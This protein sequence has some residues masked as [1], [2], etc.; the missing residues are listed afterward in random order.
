[1][2]TKMI[3]LVFWLFFLREF[4]L[5]FVMVDLHVD[6]DVEYVANV[7]KFTPTCNLSMSPC[8]VYCT[9]FQPGVTLS[10][11]LV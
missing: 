2:I 1:M 10:G 3:Y 8:P 4:F 9:G 7:I 11:L 6:A 5:F